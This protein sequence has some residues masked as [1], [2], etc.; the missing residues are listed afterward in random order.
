MFT[1]TA[2]ITCESGTMQ[3]GE[4]IANTFAAILVIC[5]LAFIFLVTGRLVF[6]RRQARM[7]V[8]LSADQDTTA[9][10][11]NTHPRLPTTFNLALAPSRP[12]GRN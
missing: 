5:G 8:I 6:P 3:L 11:I 4:I 1:R 10:I 2:G 9:S 12:L 7:V